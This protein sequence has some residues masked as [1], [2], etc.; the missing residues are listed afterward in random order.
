MNSKRYKVHTDYLIELAVLLLMATGT[1]FVF[2]AGATVSG[3]YDWKRFYDFTALKQ[4]L[5]FPAA[6]GLMYAVSSI[7]YRRFSFQNGFLR[8]LTTWLVALGLA[9]LVVVLLF[10]V[11]RNFSRRWLDLAPG[12]AYV[13]FQPSE[14]AKWAVVIFLA[15][16]LSRFSQ[17]KHSFT[18]FFLIAAAVPAIAVSLIVS[19]DFG[20]AA[21]IAILAFMMLWLG[22]A[23][24]WHLLVPMLVAVPGFI[25]AILVSPTRIKRVTDFLDPDVISYQAHQSLLAISSGQW[26]GRGLGRG[27]LKYGHLPEDTTDFIFSIVCEELGFAGAIMVI[28][29][30]VLFL[31]LGLR[32]V[33]RSRDPFAKLL[34]AGIVLAIVLQAVINIGVV[35]VVLPTKGIPLPLISAGGTSML[36]TAAAVGILLNIAR[37]TIAE[38]APGNKD[39]L[40]GRS[41][42]AAV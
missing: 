9:L 42:G 16:F 26:F 8:S 14:L 18:G 22:G 27:V 10:G 3:Q 21:F 5:F 37:T 28:I 6:V 20:T 19:E 34:S 7:D 39:V 1:V 29:L 40:A 24:W 12:P 13:S 32:V 33:M 36:L 35:T 38:A 15:A 41:L 11:E 31:V 23:V 25:T 4:F 2:S 30:F 17:K